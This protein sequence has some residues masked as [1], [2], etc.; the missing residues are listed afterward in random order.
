MALKDKNVLTASTGF[1][2]T[3]S[4]GLANPTPAEITAFNPA[5]FG[6]IQYDLEVTASSGN[7]KLKVGTPGTDTADIPFDSTEG[8][9]QTTLEAHAGV[10]EGNVLVEAGADDGEF[11]VTFVGNLQGVNPTL[12]I[13]GTGATVTLKTA[14]NGWTMVGHTSRED[15]PEFGNDGGDT[16]VKGTWQNA[17]LK[18][19]QTEALSEYLTMKINQIDRTSLTLY[20]G[21]SSTPSVPGV[22][23]VSGIPSYVDKALL[24]VVV[25]GDLNLGFSAPKC[26]FRREDSIELATDEFT[27]IPVRATFLKLGVRDLYRWI[28]EDLFD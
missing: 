20:H 1:I 21:E 10:G 28:S 3:G 19:V 6:C 7:Y 9:I 27:G 23:G 5:T 4:P 15:L 13:S 26:S 11:V 16:E 2:Y 14:L 17:S 24:I 18:E 25:D 22:F 8:A 12:A